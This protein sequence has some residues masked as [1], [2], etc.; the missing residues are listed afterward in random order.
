MWH[1]GLSARDRCFKQFP[2]TRAHILDHAKKRVWNAR[3]VPR[4]LC[5]ILSKLRRRAAPRPRHRS[6]VGPRVL[7]ALRQVGTMGSGGVT[8]VGPRRTGS[9]GSPTLQGEALCCDATLVSP[10]DTQGC[11]QMASL[12][13]RRAGGRGLV[14][15]NSPVPGHSAPWCWQSRSAGGGTVMRSPCSRFS[16]A[17]VRGGRRRRCAGSWPRRWWSLL[18][19]A[20]QRAVCST[21]LGAVAAATPAHGGGGAAA[22]RR[23]AACRCKRSEP[24]PSSRLRPTPQPLNPPWT[25]EQ[26]RSLC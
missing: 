26:T 2:E 18:S 25:P 6:V 10:L 12:G 5:L 13:P 8:S 7:P 11:P 19:V 15:R 3:G 22:R 21:V 9:G 24:S 17:C 20:A 4:R 1:A 23:L 14:S 16:L